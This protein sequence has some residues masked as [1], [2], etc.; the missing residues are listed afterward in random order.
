MRLQ[1]PDRQLRAVDVLLAGDRFR[2]NGLEKASRDAL[3][4]ST[5]GVAPLSDD[6]WTRGKCALRSI[7]YGGHALPTVASPVGITHQVV[8]HGGPDTSRRPR[9]TRLDH[10]QALLSDTRLASTLGEQALG[11]MSAPRIPT[12]LRWRSGRR[13]SRR[14]DSVRPVRPRLHGAQEPPPRDSRGSKTR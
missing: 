4:S 10:L 1:T 11:L 5:V 13:C 12:R 8:R 3:L 9:I 6:P 2:R 7:Q 14:S